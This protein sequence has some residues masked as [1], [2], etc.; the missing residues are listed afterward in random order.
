LRESTS[1][2]QITIRNLT[3][4]DYEMIT[5]VWKRA[6][7]PIK[8][9]GRDSRESIEAQMKDTPEFFIG[10]E[11]NGELVG[12]IIASCERQKGWLNRIAIVPEKRGRGI[13]ILLAQKAEEVL[14]KKGVKI[15]ALLIERDNTVSIN[16]A[17][18]LGFVPAPH[19][20]YLTKRDSEEV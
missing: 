6:G 17:K 15:I 16:L 11:E 5:D 10:A 20:L 7:L 12:V 9:K 2:G 18:K 19:I 1:G 4:D 3:I 14:R 8:P 13:A